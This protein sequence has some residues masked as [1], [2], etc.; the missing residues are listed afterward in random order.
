MRKR[1]V[2]AGGAGFIG[3]NLCEALAEDGW[4][5]AVID[6]CS[7]GVNEK[8]ARELS[9]V[10]LKKDAAALE[11]Y[12]AEFLFREADA[13]F[14]L[15]GRTWHGRSMTDPAG[16][17]HANI[18]APLAVLGWAREFCPEAHVIYTGTRG[19]YGRIL[20]NPVGEDH[21][22][23]PLDVNGANKL[24]AEEAH[25]LFGRHHGMKVTALRLPN[26]FGPR[27]QT[28]T[29]DGVVN[30]FIT[31]ALKGEEITVYGGI[32]DI[33]CVCEVS[34]ALTRCVNIP[35]CWG[36]AFNIGGRGMRLA[37]YARLVAAA[38]PTEVAE[39]VHPDTSLEIGDYVADASAF[40]KAC[41]WELSAADVKDLVADAVG[42][43][44]ERL[45]D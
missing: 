24:A 2:V 40:R 5:I 9:H 28:E 29:P 21:P 7:T 34:N 41:G 3:A 44:R 1:A 14:N 45:D 20:R 33:L 13:V 32:R 35:A 27:H 39:I 25:L 30:W 4:H 37:E 8:E 6:D 26:I 17:A 16:D 42:W 11:R 12:E 18:T 36:K 10:F 38:A 22:M 15:I 19:Q 23:I 43:Y 31:Q